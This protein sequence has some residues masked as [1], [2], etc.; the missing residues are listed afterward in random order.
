MS[1]NS[2]EWHRRRGQAASRRCSSSSATDSRRGEHDKV[3]SRITLA[4][5]SCSTRT[6]PLSTSSIRHE[7]AL[8][9]RAH[10]RRERG[11]SSS[12]STRSA[13]RSMAQASPPMWPEPA[14]CLRIDERYGIRDSIRAWT[15]APVTARARS[16]WSDRLARPPASRRAAGRE[17]RRR[18][19]PSGRRAVR[20]VARHVR[21]IALEYVELSGALAARDSA[22]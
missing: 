16:S 22:S 12:R 10:P 6:G 17:P 2:V 7:R 19:V 18:S 15:L 4:A 5:T 14:G 9:A 3:L 20:R 8:V 11:E 1:K 13:S 21:R